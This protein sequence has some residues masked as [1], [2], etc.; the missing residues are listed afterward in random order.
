M[1]HRVVSSVTSPR[2]TLAMVLSSSHRMMVGI[3]VCRWKIAWT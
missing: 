1:G 3:A 2:L